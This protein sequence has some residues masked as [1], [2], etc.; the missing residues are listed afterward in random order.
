MKCLIL[1]VVLIVANGI[2]TYNW[3]NRTNRRN[4]NIQFNLCDKVNRI[5]QYNSL[6]TKLSIN[7][8][9]RIQRIERYLHLNQEN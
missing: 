7:Q 2:I 1:S 6:N 4:T 3:V 5:D 9:N 8:E